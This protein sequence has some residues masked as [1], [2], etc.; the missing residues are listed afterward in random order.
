MKIFERNQIL[1]FCKKSWTPCYRPKSFEFVLEVFEVL[2]LSLK[3]CFRVYFL[4]KI[5]IIL[6]NAK[7]NKIIWVIFVV[8]EC[9]VCNVYHQVHLLLCRKYTSKFLRPVFLT[10]A[11]LK[12]VFTRVHGQPILRQQNLSFAMLERKEFFTCL[13]ELCMIL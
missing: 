8:A 2:W 13:S 1:T 7:K 10:V 11:S 9:T 6:N 3:L 5:P 12:K 4:K